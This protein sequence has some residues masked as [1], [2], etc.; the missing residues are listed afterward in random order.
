MSV[1]R[2]VD[3]VGSHSEFALISSIRK[4]DMF[5]TTALVVAVCFGTLAMQQDGAK[6]K[7]NVRKGPDPAA[8]D[9]KCPYSGGPA[10]KAMAANFG[11]GEVFFCCKDCLGKFNTMKAKMNVQLF[12][13]KQVKQVA[14]PISG[15]PVKEGNEVAFASAKVGFCCGNCKSKGTEMVKKD[16]EAAVL[17]MF[18][19][20]MYAK[21]FKSQ[22]QLNQKKR[23]SGKKAE[24][25]ADAK[26]DAGK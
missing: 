18:T 23:A 9:A 2:R 26:S 22:R 7:K 8:F 19:G 13:T 11:G 24:T 17:T 12:Q 1:R 16:A 3:T 5:K 4:P 10:K 15:R 14:C 20:K 25:K 6:K 21:G